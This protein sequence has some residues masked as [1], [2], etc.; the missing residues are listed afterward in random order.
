MINWNYELARTHA[1]SILDTTT[2][3]LTQFFLTQ[4]CSLAFRRYAVPENAEID[5]LCYVRCPG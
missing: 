3:R 1:D 5:L 4:F 2:R